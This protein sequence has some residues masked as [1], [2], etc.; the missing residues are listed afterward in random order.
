MFNVY[1]LYS[2]KYDRIYIGYTSDLEKR[3]ESHNVRATKGYTIRYRP[4][5][6]VYTEEFLTKP[7]A[8]KRERELKSS[9]GRSWI[10]NEILKA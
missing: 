5:K 2:G 10:R 3:L 8:I 4:W 1:V 9:R 7:E 6:L